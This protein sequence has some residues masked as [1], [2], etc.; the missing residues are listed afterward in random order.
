MSSAPYSKTLWSCPRGDQPNQAHTEPCPVQWAGPRSCNVCHASKTHITP[1]LRP[2]P[3]TGAGDHAGSR[4]PCFRPCGMGHSR[5]PRGGCLTGGPDQGSL[6]SVPT[7]GR[8][9]KGRVGQVQVV[10]VR[11]HTIQVVDK[12]VEVPGGKVVASEING[13]RDS[14]TTL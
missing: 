8:W 13:S 11:L 1:H 2:T 6:R 10:Q 5:V 3:P 14:P 12:D 4:Q 7:L 9:S